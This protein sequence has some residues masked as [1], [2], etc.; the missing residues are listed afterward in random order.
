MKMGVSN[1]F[2]KAADATIDTVAPPR[3]PN[4][5]M[6]KTAAMKAPRVFLF[7]YSDMIVAE[8]G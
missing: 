2:L 1:A 8:S 6:A 4:P 5:C 7:A 3:I